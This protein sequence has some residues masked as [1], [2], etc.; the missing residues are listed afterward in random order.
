M[1]EEMDVSVDQA[2]KQSGVAEI[3]HFA[4]RPDA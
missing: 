1:K 3:Q 4:R 2:G